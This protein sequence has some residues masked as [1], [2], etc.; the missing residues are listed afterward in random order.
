MKLS[1]S[2]GFLLFLVI[3]I[4]LSILLDQ[5]DYSL[6]KKSVYGDAID[7]AARPL[8]VERRRL[9]DEQKTLMQEQTQQRLGK[10]V[11]TF[12]FTEL[13]SKL[14]EKAFPVMDKN[15]YVG[16]LALSDQQFPGKEG[17]ISIKEYQ[18]LLDHGWKTC[19]YWDAWTDFDT[20]MSDMKEQMKELGKDLPKIIYF[21]PDRYKDEYD[22]ELEEYGFQIVVHH[23]EGEYSLI[24]RA[25]ESK[26]WHIA[27]LSWNRS[28]I[29]AYINKVAQYGGAL[30]L[31]VDFGDKR[32]GYDKEIFSNMCSY[33]QSLKER[34][35]VTDYQESRSYRSSIG[36]NMAIQSEI[37]W[38]QNEIDEINREIEQIYKKN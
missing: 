14:Y 26:I 21:A 32:S 24:T 12:V 35:I 1:K 6:S 36:I 3:C 18:D 2:N 7:Q 23:G 20:Y 37:D 30:S 16:V 34:L 17:C 8:R 4:G 10:G 28:G 25:D 11:I 29:K 13:S 31:A 22:K 15:E 33:M 38:Y 9:E 19:I 27:A 5:H